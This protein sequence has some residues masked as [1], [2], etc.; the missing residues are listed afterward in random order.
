MSVKITE[1]DRLAAAFQDGFTNGNV[2]WSET[3]EHHRD[4]F[5]D[6]VRSLLSAHTAEKGEAE[7]VAWR[8]RPDDRAVWQYSEGR[9]PNHISG[10]ISEPLYSAP[11]A[12]PSDLVAEVERLRAALTPFANGFIDVSGSAVILGYPNAKAA[13]DDARAALEGRTDA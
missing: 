7:P 12:P 6:G 4:N 9:Q 1:L 2:T 5:R 10:W 3:P 8:Y 13:I 11:P